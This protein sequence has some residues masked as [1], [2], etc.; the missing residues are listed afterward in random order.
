MF[1]TR[2]ISGIVLVL[3]MLLFIIPGG[4]LLLLGLALLSVRGSYE[5]NRVLGI[6]KEPVSVIGY[7][8]IL[9]YYTN[10]RFEYLSDVMVIFMVMMVALLFVFVLKY[11]NL[12]FAQL[13]GVVFGVFYVGIMLSYIYQLRMIEPIGAYM[14]WLIII[15]TWGCDTCAYCIGMLFGKHKMSPVLSPKKSIEG[16]FGGVIGSGLIALVYCLIF[17]NKM[18]INNTGVLIIVVIVMIAALISMIGD[19]SAS[20]IKR[21]YD[22]KDYGR[23]I[24]GHGGVL[25]RFDS[26]IICAPIIYYLVYYTIKFAK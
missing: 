22:I 5:L 14:V 4:D 10:L 2:L 18:S 19:L 21:F 26:V 23:L 15:S 1:W 16:A 8:S 24:P 3:L 12:N 6:H 11:P 20:A 9:V 7:V 17:R 25:D 13:G